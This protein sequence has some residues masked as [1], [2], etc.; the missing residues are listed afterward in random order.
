MNFGK[1]R[2]ISHPTGKLFFVSRVGMWFKG[3]DLDYFNFGSEEVQLT[4][5][6]L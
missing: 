6:L 2:E 4:F 5:S 1:A 3:H